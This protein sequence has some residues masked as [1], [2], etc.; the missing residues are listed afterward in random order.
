MI[1]DRWSPSFRLSDSRSTTFCLISSMILT[2]L[3]SCSPSSTR[4]EDMGCSDHLFPC[5]SA[6]PHRPSPPSFSALHFVSDAAGT[7]FVK[8]RRQRVPCE[9]PGIRGA[10]SIDISPTGTIWL[11]CRVTWPTHLLLTAKDEEHHQNHGR[12]SDLL[13]YPACP[14]GVP[15]KMASETLCGLGPPHGALQGRPGQDEEGAP[16]M[17]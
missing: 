13:S 10:A 4:S 6:I 15:N 3:W 1:L 14:A 12:A 17:R 9:T 2:S 16:L 8:V 5:L 7:R 11:C